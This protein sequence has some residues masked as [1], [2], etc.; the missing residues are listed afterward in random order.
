MQ[1]QADYEQ[2]KKD[3]ILAKARLGERLANPE[4]PEPTKPAVIVKVLEGGLKATLLLHP[5]SPRTS[6]PQKE[7]LLAALA[8]QGIVHGVN[9]ELLEDLCVK[10]VYYHVFVIARGVPAQV[11]EDGFVEYLVSTIRNHKPR[12][13]ENGVADYKNIDFFQVVHTGQRLCTIHPARKGTDGLDVHGNVLEGTYG[14]EPM[15]PAGRNTVLGEEGTALF[16]AID[17]HVNVIYGVVHVMEVLEIGENVDLSTGNIDYTGDVVVGGDVASGFSVRCGG[18]ILVR[19]S[20]EGAV[21]EA[22][23]D[24]NVSVGMLGMDK[25][26]VSAGGSVKCK[27]IQNCT[28]RASGGIY[29]DSILFSDVEC[30]GDLELSGK[31]GALIGGSAKVGGKVVAKTIGTSMHVLTEIRLCP[32]GLNQNQ[33]MEQLNK[34]IDGLNAETQTILQTLA[35]YEELRKKSRL[36]EG[37]LKDML[38]ANSRYGRIIQRR[39]QAQAELDRIKR[40]QGEQCRENSYVECSGTIYPNTKIEV[41]NEGIQVSNPIGRSR[42]AV[43]QNGIQI[44]PL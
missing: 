27:F 37:Q 28:V 41:G 22:G 1:H 26:L 4:E 13:D 12:I 10:P 15:D 31:K 14:K 16:A 23:T 25:G 2:I 36:N 24:I 21:L 39:E 33:V 38:A 3:V 43:E 44:S 30:G 7:E 18:S 9:M 42:V 8:E 32:S 40:E 11:G 29:A 35:R 19:G 5:T 20:V 6:A 17:G 34:E